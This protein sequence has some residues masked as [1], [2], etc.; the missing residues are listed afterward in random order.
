[1]TIISFEEFVYKLSWILLPSANATRLF[2]TL[3][4]MATVPVQ[5]VDRLLQSQRKYEPNVDVK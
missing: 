3:Y 4:S 2:M 5:S 1:M